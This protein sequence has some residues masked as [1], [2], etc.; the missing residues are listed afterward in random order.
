MRPKCAK[1]R[2]APA[3]LPAVPP[4]PSAGLLGAAGMGAAA[5]KAAP[6]FRLGQCTRS[7]I[8]PH[9]DGPTCS[10]NSADHRALAGRMPLLSKHHRYC[11]AERPGHL[12]SCGSTH[13]G[14]VTAI[15]HDGQALETEGRCGQAEKQT[16][17]G[18]TCAGGG[19]AHA[20]GIFTANAGG[21]AKR[22]Q[23][24]RGAAVC[25]VGGTAQHR[26]A[27]KGE[28]TKLMQGERGAALCVAGGTAQDSAKRR[29][30]KAHAGGRGAALCVAGG[31]AQDSAKRREDK[32]HA[33]GEGRGACGRHS[34]EQR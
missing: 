16:M 30:D 3:S 27:P 14:T 22:M 5:A 9:R 33:G 17:M 7:R 4:C 12:P 31:T 25:A 24:E 28:W 34:S 32:A 18:G 23:G 10:H 8:Q 15:K 19:R 13:C 6:F 1:R 21:R 29:V 2:G 20:G 11:W 26:T